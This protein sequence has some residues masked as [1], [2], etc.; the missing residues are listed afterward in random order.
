MF[1]YVTA[2]R[3]RGGDPHAITG[4][5]WQCINIALNILIVHYKYIE[6]IDNIFIIYSQ[7]MVNVLTVH[8]NI[9]EVHALHE[10]TEIRRS[11]LNT[12]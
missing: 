5:A 8:A 2:L 7:C 10:C 3:L 11:V 12:M 4:S 1:G 9:L 6:Y